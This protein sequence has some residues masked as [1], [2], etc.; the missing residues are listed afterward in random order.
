MSSSHRSQILQRGKDGEHPTGEE[1]F[2]SD[3]LEALP[4]DIILTIF[5]S[6]RTFPDVLSF[7]LS[8]R[9]VTE[10]LDDYTPSIYRP[11]AKQEIE[12]ESHARALL[13]D[14]KGLG[15]L[16]PEPTSLKVQDIRRLM[17]NS[18]MA[19]QSANWFGREIAPHILSR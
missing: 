10:L 11:I 7:A 19:N 1:G 16:V 5:Y 4:D 18:L 8:C 14:Q 12:H 2:L 13:R 6:L 15:C 3:R 9:R 17:R